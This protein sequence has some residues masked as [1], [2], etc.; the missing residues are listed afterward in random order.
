MLVDD[1]GAPAGYSF[2]R[3]YIDSGDPVAAEAYSPD[4]VI[5]PGSI[6]AHALR[7]PRLPHLLQAQ[8]EVGFQ[9][10]SADR[11]GAPAVAQQGEPRARPSKR[12][13]LHLDQG[14]QGRSSSAGRE[15]GRHI[16][17]FLIAHDL[18]P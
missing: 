4:K 9:T 14:G 5:F 11:S 18:G 16:T 1:G 6:V 12:R 17:R 8:E 13:A 2:D 3:F 10:A 15:Q 7:L